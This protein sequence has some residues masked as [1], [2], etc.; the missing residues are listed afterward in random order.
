[1]S[2]DKKDKEAGTDLSEDARDRKPAS[3]LPEDEK[4]RWTRR[5]NREASTG[6]S[7]ARGCGIA[8]G[9]AALA[10]FLIVGACFIAL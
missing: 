9:I 1:M 4:Y 2:E 3:P 6:S 10:F 8:L 7:F 5:E